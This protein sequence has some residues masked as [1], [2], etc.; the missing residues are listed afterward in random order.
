MRDS[1]EVKVKFVYYDIENDL[2]TES[3][4]A[5]KVGDNYQIKNIPFFAP[6]IAYDDIINVEDDDGELFFDEIVKESGNSTIQIIVFTETDVSVITK[7]LEELSCGWE[8]S[9]LKTYISVNV[10]K[11][12]DYKPVKDFLDQKVREKVLDYK[13]ACLAHK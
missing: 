1:S 5:I 10:P 7:S 13:E 6:N 2:E 11:H 4:W 3:V 12:V 9:H 8:G